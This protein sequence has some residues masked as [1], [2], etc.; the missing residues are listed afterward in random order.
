MILS[1]IPYLIMESY[2]TYPINN[3]MIHLYQNNFGIMKCSM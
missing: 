2:E 1:L 3:I